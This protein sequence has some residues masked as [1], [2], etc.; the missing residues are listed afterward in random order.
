MYTYMYTILE[1]FAIRCHSLTIP[2]LPRN[3]FLAVKYSKN[4]AIRH[5]KS[6]IVIIWQQGKQI[7]VIGFEPTSENCQPV[8]NKRLTASRVS[9]LA[10]SLDKT[11]QKYPE[12][13]QII[14]AWP[15]LPEHIKAAIK[16]LIES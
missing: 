16:A 5:K 10:T 14:T 12:L 2:E 13:E 7:G 1:L 15:E 9:V 6:P 8:D 11:L 3:D 4:P